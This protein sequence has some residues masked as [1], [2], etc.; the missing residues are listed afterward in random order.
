MV[1]GNG[2]GLYTADRTSAGTIIVFGTM[3]TG[4]PTGLA[5]G[6]SR[7]SF[8]NNGVYGNETNG[9]FTGTVAQQ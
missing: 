5:G 8:G 1:T 7:I 6:G 2:G 9:S 3:I 4:N